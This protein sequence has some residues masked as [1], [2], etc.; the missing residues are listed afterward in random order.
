[1]F[2]L[3]VPR[4]VWWRRRVCSRCYLR[5]VRYR[6][7]LVREA[8]CVASVRRGGIEVRHVV[9]DQY[10]L[11]SDMQ[12]RLCIIEALGCCAWAGE[13]RTRFQQLLGRRDHLWELMD[14]WPELLLQ[15]A[16]AGRD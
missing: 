13:G 8:Q 3:V 2:R 11:G 9:H 7:R 6:D 5:C 16:D 14:G 10:T 1:M 4:F 12:T 15:V